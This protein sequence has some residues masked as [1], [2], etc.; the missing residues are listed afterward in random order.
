MNQL[1]L[2]I[3]SEKTGTTAIQHFLAMNRECLA[4]QG[5]IYPTIGFSDIA[6]FSLVAP[7]H[8]L[9]QEG[10]PL[11]FAPPGEYL[12]EKEWAPVKEIFDSHSDV[13]VILSAEHFSSRLR[14]KGI[15]ALANVVSWA[16]SGA[17]V[18]IL[19]YVRRQDEYFQSAYSTYV[20]TGGTWSAQ[21]YY[22]AIAD[23]PWVYDYYLIA[24]AWRSAFPDACLKVVPFERPQLS[25][26]LL[27][28]FCQLAGI[29]P[30]DELDWETHEPN[31]SWSKKS[32]EFA[33]LFNQYCESHPVD[34]R[35]QILDS[36]SR[37]LGRK[38][39][40]LLPPAVLARFVERYEE[41]NERLA[42][43]F[44][45]R[46]DGSLFFADP[47]TT[48]WLPAEALSVSDL[49]PVL[50]DCLGHDR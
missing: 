23:D 30:V 43:E 41:S 45:G 40:T 15:G 21:D 25:E 36:V 12:A 8:G 16:C 3:G 4:S 24:S 33:R 7:F 19:Y 50:A 34:G 2:H 11:E 37:Y 49:F 39:E 44:L 1:F 20:K 18:T 14:A 5:I 31:E 32:L 9:D 27:R 29:T 13:S 6:H 28:H 48:E 46:N 42:K 22:D 26:G 38:R 35:F 10:R 17:K 47:A